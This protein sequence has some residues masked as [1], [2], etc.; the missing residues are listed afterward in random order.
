[1]IVLLSLA[2]GF[3][4]RR[5]D[6]RSYHYGCVGTRDFIQYW[7]AYQALKHSV[8]PYDGLELH[9][10]EEAVGQSP[11]AT[12]FMWNPPWTPLLLAPVLE[13]G[14]P[15]SCLTWM[16]CNLIIVV[17]IGVAVSRIS[18]SRQSLVLPAIASAVFFYPVMETI[19]LGQTSLLPALE[20]TLFLWC[21]A[22]ENDFGAGM[23]LVLLS[24]KPHLFLI[25]GVW[26]AY[27][28]LRERRWFVAV[29]FMFGLSSMALLTHAIWQRALL[30]WWLSFSLPPQGP[31][32]EPTSNWITS[33]IASWLRLIIYYKTGCVDLWPMIVIPLGAITGL[34]LYL[35]LVRP[36]IAWHTQLHPIL[37]L[38]VGLAPY[39]WPFDYSV[40]VIGQILLIC[41][42]YESNRSRSRAIVIII[43]SL[44]MT[45]IPVAV[46]SL[47]YGHE[48]LVWYPW[49]SLAIWTGTYRTVKTSN[50]HTLGFD[51]RP[52]IT[53]EK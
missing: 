39:G 33:S 10:I 37:C 46:E 3:L 2:L 6:V 51:T 20:T 29:A 27:F 42:M 1:M 9:P 7:S 45:V 28:V 47:R 13:L 26:I 31:G 43:S 11:H 16:V 24:I 41:A 52:A 44:F 50:T 40:L 4:A 34:V 48:L 22:K 8:N 32:A 5:L 38:S 36:P 12:I 30:N 21:M 35:Y 14:F 23:S 25:F 53:L 19:A 17:G 18:G 15:L 49:A